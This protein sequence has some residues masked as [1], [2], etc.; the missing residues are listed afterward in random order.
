MKYLM[1]LLIAMTMIGCN[2]SSTSIDENSTQVNTEVHTPPVYVS[3]DFNV[4][5][6]MPT[7]DSSSSG[8]SSSSVS[9]YVGSGASYNVF[10]VYANGTVPVIEDSWTYY[11]IQNNFNSNCTYRIVLP[12]N[13]STVYIYDENKLEHPKLFSKGAYVF[14]SNKSLYMDLYSVANSEIEIFTDCWLEYR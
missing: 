1:M 10:R 12:V 4:T 8:S 5:I 3:N 9:N 13:V 7:E 2:G 14:D 11:K 6:I